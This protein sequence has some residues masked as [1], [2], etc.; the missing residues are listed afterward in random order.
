MKKM[1]IT[2]VVLAVILINIIIYKNMVLVSKNSIKVQEIEN[3]QDCIS[4]VYMWKEITKDALP[5]FD[6]INNADDIWLWEVVKKNL[7][8]YEL[9]YEEIEAKAKEIFGE[10]FNKQFPKGG[11]EILKYNETIN[12]YLATETDFDEMEDNFLLNNIEK[13]QEGY[14]V[15]I[16]EYLEDYSEEDRVIV[17]N[18]QDEEIGRADE[19]ESETKIYEIIK[20][21]I[22]RF[23][24]K[25]VYIKKI[26][27]R[28]SIQK[29]QDMS[30]QM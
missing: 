25:E 10:N 14:T 24:K 7:E 20:S 30:T 5:V 8:N 23:N 29:V 28:L 15:E 16:I 9:T 22:D 17:R 21:N 18:L 13:T 2:I 1:L 26:D 19:H 27:G 11:N 12:K 4:K 3:I 6:D